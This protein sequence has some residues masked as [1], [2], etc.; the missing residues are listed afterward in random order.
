MSEDEIINRDYDLYVITKLSLPDHNEFYIDNFNTKGLPE[1]LIMENINTNRK[2]CNEFFIDYF[3]TKGLPKSLIS[4][5]INS[6][7]NHCMKLY[8]LT[9]K[10][11]DDNIKLSLYNKKHLNF[12]STIPKVENLIDYIKKDVKYIKYQEHDE[13]LNKAFDEMLKKLN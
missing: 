6:N 4:D 2:F 11:Y 1:S 5:K 3:N 13:R 9:A 12:Q 8:K 7:K 10:F